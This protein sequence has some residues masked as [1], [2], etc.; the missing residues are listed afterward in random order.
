[1]P[2][3]GCHL[4]SPRSTRID[5]ARNTGILLI[6]CP[7]RKGLVAAIA[8]FLYQPG[9]NI[10]HADQHQDNEQGLFFMRVEFSLADFDLDEVAFSQLFHP[11]ASEFQMNWR[12]EYSSRQIRIAIFVSRYLHCLADL[13]HRHQTGELA[14]SIAAVISNHG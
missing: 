12:L 1:M 7:D 6:D 5:V 2:G 14:C 13:L 10:L 8:N 3:G 4:T 11:I 9:A